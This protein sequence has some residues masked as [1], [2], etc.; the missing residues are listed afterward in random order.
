M[1]WRGTVH[2]FKFRPSW[3]AIEA[4]PWDEQWRHL[5]D[6]A[7]KA[8][9]LAE[10]NVWPET[11][12]LPLLMAVAL[13]WQLQYEMGDGFNYEPTQAE[14]IACHGGGCRQGPGRLCL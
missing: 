13:G 10:D 2:P 3:Q 5:Q 14:T 1:A 8:K 4:L 7:F 11:D 9:L 6:P 12:V